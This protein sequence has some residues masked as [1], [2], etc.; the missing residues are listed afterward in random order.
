MNPVFERANLIMVYLVGVMWVAVS[1]GRGPAILASFLSVA[2]FD[3][4]F[5][6]PRFAFGVSDTQYLVTFGVMLLAAIVIGTL[7]ARLQAQLRS[8]RIDEHRSDAL[9][10]FS[11]ELVAL[12]DRDRILAA[13]FAPGAVVTQ[14]ARQNDVSTGL[15]YTP[16]T[17]ASTEEVIALAAVAARHGKPYV[18]HL[19]DE[20]S[21]VEEAMA[22]AVDIARRSGAALHGS[23]R[24]LGVIAVAPGDIRRLMAPDSFRLL[25][26]FAN[27]AALALERAALAEQ[28]EG[29]RLQSETERLR[30]GLLSSVSH[31]LRTPLAVITGATSSL[32]EGATTL[33]P[34]TRVELAQTVLKEPDVV[35]ALLERSASD[36]P[37]TLA[38]VVEKRA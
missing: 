8:A 35:Y 10:K 13:A 26:A 2:T 34:A 23:S 28:A 11:R 38:A 14:V 27:H 31:D 29:A 21:R 19:R 37:L 9:A 4:F 24:E 1:L 32:V 16:G 5:V 30:S 25:Q 20:M 7:A 36:A 12:Q 22:E 6:P 18:T 15:I 3:F 17:Y 33:E